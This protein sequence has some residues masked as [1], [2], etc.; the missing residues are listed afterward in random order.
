VVKDAL[1]EFGQHVLQNPG[2]RT[3]EKHPIVAEVSP[4]QRPG[5]QWQRVG[6]GIRGHVGMLGH[7]DSV[8]RIALCIKSTS[9]WP[10]ATAEFAAAP[11]SP[12]LAF[13]L[14]GTD[15]RRVELFKEQVAKLEA[16]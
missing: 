10:S 2:P 8:T 4:D 7:R 11:F 13:A 6:R 3:D 16:V 9:A 1:A 5:A 12:V 15:G 14:A